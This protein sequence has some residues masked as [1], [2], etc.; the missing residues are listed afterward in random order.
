MFK[1]YD[2]G[3]DDGNVL[4]ISVVIVAL[5]IATGMG[6]MQWSS[7]ERWDSAYEEATVQAYFLAQMGVIEQ[8]LQ[9]L[10]TREPSDLPQ[11]TV[12]LPSK[13]VPDVGQY[14]STKVSRVVS[15]G[16]GSVFQ[17]SDTYDVYSTGKTSFVD[18]QLG[19]RKYGQKKYVERT[20]TMRA[21]LRS[22]ANYMYLTNYEVTQFNEIIWFWTPDTLY[23][24]THSNDFIGLKYSPTFYGPISTSQDR[25]RYNAVGEVHF[26]YPPQFNVPPVYFPTTATS[27]RANARP[28]ISSHNGAFM[29]WIEFLGG[30]GIEVYQYRLGTPPRDSS[31]MHL[32]VPNWQAIFVDGQVEVE[33][34]FQGTLTLGSAGDMWLIDNI[35]Y[36]GA[37]AQTGW[38]G[39]MTVTEGNMPHMLGLVSEK[40]IIIRNNYVNG[41]ENGYRQFPGNHQRHSIIINAGMVALGESFTFEHQND[42]WDAY[43]GPDPYDERGYIYLKGAVTQWRRGYVHRSNHVGTGYGKSYNYDFRFDRR[44]PPFYLEAMDENG[45]GLFDIISWG[46]QAPH[47]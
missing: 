18:H 12:L 42:E 37:D 36:E 25:F 15:L 32:P 35:R 4:I 19:N 27:I 44:P 17:R 33:G 8:G 6:Y 46:E 24:R 11:G 43:Q 21:R 30:D 9:Y 22:F 40:N 47:K 31:I 16:S 29:T 3:K 1:K 34:V 7:D 14:H 26:E 2:L 28:T 23:G 13:V 5:L 39:D 20:A 45:H 10:R 41:R 38:F